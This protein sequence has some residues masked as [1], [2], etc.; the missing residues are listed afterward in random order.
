MGECIIS[1]GASGSGGSSSNIN[2]ASNGL[3]TE[4]YVHNTI[5]RVPQNLRNN[6]VSVRLFGGG[7]GGISNNFGGYGG[8]MNN[9]QIDVS[10]E[11]D[12]YIYI[13]DGGTTT[14]GTTSFG[15]YL[16]ATGGS[17]YNGGSSGGYALVTATPV[18]PTYGGA[19]G[20]AGYRFN[21]NTMG[22]TSKTS[23]AGIYGGGAGC[24]MS[25]LNI[26]YGGTY[27]G[28]N[29]AS[30]EIDAEN[31]VNTAGL[32]LDFEG[33]GLPGVSTNS[34][35]M[36]NGG[37][38]IRGS[39][40]GGGYGGNGGN[41]AISFISNVSNTKT[42]LFVAASGG[43]GG[44]GS[45]GGDGYA[46]ASN[47][48]STYA[49]AGGG[50]GGYGGDGGSAYMNNGGGGG[51]YGKHGKGGGYHNINGVNTFCSAGIAAGGYGGNGEGGSG[52][53]IIQY[54]LD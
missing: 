1:R 3:I 45:N 36:N 30:T 47:N 33:F 7:G 24:I 43:G 28:G 37:I 20:I 31:G 17:G 48:A 6:I 38:V 13:G 39:G 49:G 35:T 42:Q 54:Y 21:N 10:N 40:G 26:S 25:N 9:A 46:Y 2:I 34:Y 12:I 52:I 41:G 15:T 8:N 51:G 53:C 23:N 44:Y 29:G 4:I 14:G 50:G 5:W 19:G 27:G 16:Y 18:A 32:G 22:K 11:T